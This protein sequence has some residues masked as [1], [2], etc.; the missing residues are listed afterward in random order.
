MEKQIGSLRKSLCPG[1]WVGVFQHEDGKISII[2]EGKKAS[3]LE[4]Q[5]KG[6]LKGN[7]SDQQQRVEIRSGDRLMI[8]HGGSMDKKM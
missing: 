3:F 8:I 7:D 5:D 2:F 1:K 4:T 6:S